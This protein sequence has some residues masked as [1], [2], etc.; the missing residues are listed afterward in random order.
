[1]KNV[2]T[3]CIG[4]IISAGLAAPAIADNGLQE[5]FKKTIDSS[6]TDLNFRYRYEFVDQDGVEKDANAST[7]RTRLTYQSGTFKGFALKLEADNISAVGNDLYNSTVNGNTDYP[8][9][10]DPTGTELNQAFISYKNNGLTLSAGR[11]R[12]NHNDQRFVG[13]VGWRQNEQTFDGYRFEYASGNFS[14]DYAYV[15]NVNRIFG[16]DSA[17]GDLHGDI[18]LLNSNY[19]LAD[20]HKLTGYVYEM[21]F[22]S[23][24]ALSNHT[25]GLAYDGTIGI[26]KLHAA[27]ARQTETGD[28]PVDY[29]TDYYAI[30]AGTQAGKVNVA[31]GYESLGSDN[32]VGFTTPLATLHKFQGF[33][34]KFLNTPA[35]G[36]EDLYLKLSG[37][38]GKLALTAM[39]H[40]LQAE[41]GNQD[42]GTELNLIATYPLAEKVSLQFKYA[43]Y[44][45]D[46]LAT[47]TKK[48]WTMLTMAF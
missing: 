4:S 2:L 19:K 39:W 40:D 29:S 43:D 45:A 7:L 30:E 44:N 3:L 27:Y 34:D 18:H 31:L 21:D 8:V 12:I 46:G 35:N 14:A 41:T 28:N 25:V 24:A 13:G 32:G 16:E 47:D 42:Y 5:E 11:Q 15:Y 20:N 9:V 37:K 26:A 33:A 10:V 48:F 1:M 17:S 38:L 22:D 6:K 36:V 23:A